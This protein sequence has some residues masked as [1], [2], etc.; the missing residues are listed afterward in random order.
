[1]PVSDSS[2][3]DDIMPN[4]TTVYDSEDEDPGDYVDKN[5]SEKE[6]PPLVPLPYH[7]DKLPP[8]KPILGDSD[9]NLPLLMSLSSVNGSD[10]DWDIIEDEEPEDFISTDTA[11]VALT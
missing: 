4:L 2:D 7:K 10:N 1:M 11:A 6:L 9:D 8:L 5:Q 3:D